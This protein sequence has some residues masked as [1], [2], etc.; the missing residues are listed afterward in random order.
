MGTS[1]LR[2]RYEKSVSANRYNNVAEAKRKRWEKT[3]VELQHNYAISPDIDNNSSTVPQFSHMRLPDLAVADE[4][5][6]DIDIVA[7]E[8]N[9]S[10]MY[11]ICSF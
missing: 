2:G 3:V 5:F 7:H 8:E 6:D 4:M 10:K 9:V 11:T 1:M